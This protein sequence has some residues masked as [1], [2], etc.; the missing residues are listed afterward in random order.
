MVPLIFIIVVPGIIALALVIGNT[1][2]RAAKKR[3][4][5]SMP[6]EGVMVPAGDHRLFALVKG[7]GRPPVVFENCLGGHA[8]LWSHIQE[9]LSQKTT[10]ISYDRAANGWSESRKEK[11]TS[12]AVA[13][14]LR[15]A[16]R[17]LGFEGPY[18]FVSH[19][20]GAI[21]TEHF[22]RLFPE[23]VAGIVFVDPISTD[24]RRLDEVS[25]AA[26]S[27][28]GTTEAKIKRNQR[29]AA[30]SKIG[31]KA[32]LRHSL[33]KGLGL[34]RLRLN[35]EHKRLLIDYYIL[36]RPYEISAA[37]MSNL[38]ESCELITGLGPFPDIPI[39]IIHHDPKRYIARLMT[40]G[41]TMEEAKKVEE[42]WRNL[43]HEMLDLSALSECIEA[44]E[45]GHSILYD[46][47]GIITNAI[48]D[49]LTSKEPERLQE[50]A[51]KGD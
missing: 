41:Y 16:L 49:I 45:S 21:Y 28:Y 27:K 10:T 39:K 14:E 2:L 17:N 8:F 36:P 25:S 48:E 20:I 19:S 37:E 50:G 4:E 23:S 11:A 22:A 18:I 9:K 13:F 51:S 3:Y 43:H 33:Q 40:D 1:M 44:K 32:L 5:S 12:D 26:S 47:T 31:I 29:S 35:E 30:L 34:D 38:A 7:E 42:T 46:D 15:T 24:V 6:E